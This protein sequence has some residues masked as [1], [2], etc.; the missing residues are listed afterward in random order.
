MMMIIQRQ[1]AREQGLKRY[2][3]GKVCRN[4]HY[5]ER[6]V[7]NGKCIACDY[8]RKLAQRT[9]NPEAN[10]NR[11]KA[12]QKANPEKHAAKTIAHFRA[13]KYGITVTQLK[14]MEAM[15]MGRCKTCNS[16]FTKTPHVDHCHTTGKVRG[17]LCSQCNM[18]LGL[19]KDN[20]QTLQN[21]IHYL[22]S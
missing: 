6:L 17:L 2:C 8:D 1:D 10:R 15:Q 11:V 18:A 21:M 4:G 5:S 7:C 14:L 3:T 9:K 20:P 16:P 19:I 13:K 12:W 22:N